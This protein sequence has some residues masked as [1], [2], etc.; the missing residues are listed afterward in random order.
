M[1]VVQVFCRFV[2]H[3]TGPK[4][5]YFIDDLARM[6]EALVRFTLDTLLKKYVSQIYEHC[7]LYWAAQNWIDEVNFADCIVMI[8]EIFNTSTSHYIPTSSVGVWFHGTM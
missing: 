7:L 8:D 2:G 4:T 1:P 6:E 3:T 5:Y